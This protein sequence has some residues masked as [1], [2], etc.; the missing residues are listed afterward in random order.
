LETAIPLVTEKLLGVAVGEGL[1]HGVLEQF[2][3]I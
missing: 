3:K 2:Q 1:D